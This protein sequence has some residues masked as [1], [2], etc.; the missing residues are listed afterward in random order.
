[1][2]G[3]PDINK[4]E[5]IGGRQQALQQAHVCEKHLGRGKGCV[6]G[7]ARPSQIKYGAQRSAQPPVVRTIVRRWALEAQGTTTMH[8]YIPS[9]ER[10]RFHG[11]VLGRPPIRTS[12]RPRSPLCICVSPVSCKS[13]SDPAP[14]ER[15]RPSSAAPMPLWSRSR[16]AGAQH[17]RHSRAARAQ[18]GFWGVVEGSPNLPEI[19]PKVGP[20]LANLGPTLVEID[21]WWP[22]SGRHWPISAHKWSKSTHV[23]QIRPNFDP[24]LPM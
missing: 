2:C 14:L 11:G 18:L 5:K 10:G 9:P 22:T 8:R 13:H 20:L 19:R 6:A 3:K 1:M 23:R 4:M 24:S 16:A 12:R 21:R 7:K 15:K 17:G